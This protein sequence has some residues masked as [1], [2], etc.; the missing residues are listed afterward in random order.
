MT[1]RDESAAKEWLRATAP[2]WIH[3]IGV[4]EHR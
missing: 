4:L 1:I 2:N 3:K